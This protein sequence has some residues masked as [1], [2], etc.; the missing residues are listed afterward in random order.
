M[1][2]HPEPPPAPDGAT[3]HIGWLPAGTHVR[4]T[5]GAGRSHEGVLTPWP[6]R[7]PHV[8]G[9]RVIET[10]VSE[11]PHVLPERRRVEVVYVAEEGE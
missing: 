10:V 6:D 2:S 7:P 4:W 1:S 3:I 9:V 5:D 11:I 8:E